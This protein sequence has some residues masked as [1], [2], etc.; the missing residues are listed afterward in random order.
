M[1]H[2]FLTVHGTSDTVIP[3]K[4]AHEFAKIIANHKLHI[5]EGADHGFTKH[6][7]ELASIVVNFIKESLNQE[8]GGSKI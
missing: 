8:G 7:D 6:Q 4:D 2:R 5:L 3:V 1:D